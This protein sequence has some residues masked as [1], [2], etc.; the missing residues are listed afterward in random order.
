ME[1]V[2]AAAQLDGRGI[3]PTPK[4]ILQNKYMS[5]VERK[6]QR[7][8]MRK[9]LDADTIE[10][11]LVAMRAGTA[12]MKIS[13]TGEFVPR[14][15]AVS[16]DGS[17][18]H[19][20]H[21]KHVF[22]QKQ[23]N[24]IV[25]RRK[26]LRRVFVK[27]IRTPSMKKSLL[28]GTIATAPVP[29]TPTHLRVSAANA[30]ETPRT[31]AASDVAAAEEY[32][33]HAPSLANLPSFSSFESPHESLQRGGSSDSGNI[34]TNS[35]V[36]GSGSPG[37][38]GG[39]NGNGGGNRVLRVTV[40]SESNGVVSSDDAAKG[41]YLSNADAAT[42][43]S[44]EEVDPALIVQ[45]S[46]RPPPLFVRGL[47]ELALTSGSP[48]DML[49]QTSGGSSHSY[50]SSSECLDQ[51]SDDDENNHQGGSEPARDSFND[52]SWSGGDVD[53]DD[54]DAAARSG[55]SA[56]NKSPY[57]SP[58]KAKSS[59]NS[60]GGSRGSSGSGSGGGC[61]IASPR[62]GR[63]DTTPPHMLSPVRH[64]NANEPE[65]PR[66]RFQRR[67]SSSAMVL[68]FQPIVEVDERAATPSDVP[69]PGGVHLSGGGD[70]GGD[71]SRRGSISDAKSLDGNDQTSDSD[72]DDLN[73]LG[74]RRSSV[75]SVGS[76][77]R[78]RSQSEKQR[79]LSL[80]VSLAAAAAASEA[81]MADAIRIAQLELNE[82]PEEKRAR[83]AAEK[84]ADQRQSKYWEK[85][86]KPSFFA[87]FCCG[88]G[89]GGDDEQ[90]GAA[91]YDLNSPPARRGYASPREQLKPEFARA[92]S[93]S[94]ISND[95]SQHCSVEPMTPQPSY[96]AL[97]ASRSVATAAFNDDDTKG[98]RATTPIAF[99]AG[100]DVGVAGSAF[101]LHRQLSF[102]EPSND[103][104][105]LFG[106]KSPPVSRSMHRNKGGKKP[107]YTRLLSTARCV[108]LGPFGR[109]SS[110]RFELYRARN[111][112]PW[113]CLSITFQD[114]DG[115]DGKRKNEYLCFV[116]E[117][118]A[119]VDAWLLGFQALIPRHKSFLT[120]AKVRWVR[121]LMKVLYYT[122]WSRIFLRAD[123]KKDELQTELSRHAR[124]LQLA[125]TDRTRIPVFV[126]RRPPPDD[127]NARAMSSK[128]AH[129][130]PRWVRPKTKKGSKPRAP[131]W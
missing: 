103:G 31:A 129:Y 91:K 100:D 80:D 106:S 120:L 17:E 34:Y 67:R 107:A 14:W 131:G 116:M 21:D 54:K 8:L 83:E 112:Y 79:R 98:E 6:A 73:S 114:T 85:D 99:D 101:N 66:D 22:D 122:R 2:F 95:G 56:N 48:P 49:R 52:T 77:T 10:R 81:S 24:R 47:S 41:D 53:D 124:W 108:T 36:N 119:E 68:D 72:A 30:P 57:T 44:D 45:A 97:M 75:S 25:R 118:E 64:A 84:R 115:K 42:P 125:A 40:I 89:G 18:L 39:S 65:S 26:R 104:A 127:P 61:V 130:Q 94:E 15:F 62:A 13:R 117:I 4:P 20:W 3:E 74:S 121:A 111:H 71:S 76:F 109:S 23:Y 59:S 1:A 32:V 46:M 102:R 69:Q 29:P 86:Q 11:L 90:S 58:E 92:N 9:T 63:G 126:S 110:N 37:R 78:E 60:G 16:E 82:T 33:Q 50:A 88:S 5:K 51:S 128:V 93:F 35:N 105:S 7:D 28:A 96:A 43:D 123:V 27:S 70:G 55:S 38:G 113:L 12:V 87:R 19:Y